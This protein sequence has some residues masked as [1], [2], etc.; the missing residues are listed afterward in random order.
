MKN[1]RKT[2]HTVFDEPKTI[3]INLNLELNTYKV[4]TKLIK[5]VIYY[6]LWH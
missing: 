4:L 5:R 6:D 1:C 3:I 2:S